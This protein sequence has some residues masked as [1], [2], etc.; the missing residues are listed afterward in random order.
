MGEGGEPFCGEPG[1]GF[2]S[3]R[4]PLT[5]ALSFARNALPSLS[6]NLGDRLPCQYVGALVHNVTGVTAQPVPADLMRVHRGIEPLP[7]IDILDRLF[8]GRTPAITFPSRQIGHHAIAEVLTIGVQIDP[9]RPLE[10]FKRGNG[11]HQLH[12]IVGGVCLTAFELFLVVAEGEDR[13]PAARAGIAR[14]GAVSMNDDMR[15]P[16]RRFFAHGSMTHGSITP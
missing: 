8:V 15:Q 2:G 11:G 7:Q 5:R 14:T 6:A 16:L 10:R 13:A 12:A 1:E 3:S 4:P 9:A